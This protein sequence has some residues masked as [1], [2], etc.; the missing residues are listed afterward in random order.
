MDQ[1]NRGLSHNKRTAIIEI[2]DEMLLKQFVKFH[3]DI[4]CHCIFTLLP[5]R[6]ARDGPFPHSSR[7]TLIS[8]R[9]SSF[10]IIFKLTLNAKSVKNCTTLV[11]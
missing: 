5:N 1:I 6:E 8:L 9:S 3:R 7:V 2:K 10:I 11:Q 4:A